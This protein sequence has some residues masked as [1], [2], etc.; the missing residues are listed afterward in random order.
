VWQR[1]YLSRLAGEQ[2]ELR[3]VSETFGRK[4]CLAGIFADLNGRKDGEEAL[5]LPGLGQGQSFRL[6]ASRRTP[7]TSPMAELIAAISILPL[8]SSL[9][10]A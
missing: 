7:A 5:A 9:R 3:I 4:V 6:S 10:S 2:A 8:R 1:D